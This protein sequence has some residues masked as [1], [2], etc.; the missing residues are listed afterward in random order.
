[1]TKI[2]SIPTYVLLNFGIILLC[3]FFSQLII[4]ESC[5]VFNNE[6][7]L[8]YLSLGL[9]WIFLILIIP[10]LI[11]KKLG[12][13][14]SNI[15]TK[16]FI[17]VMLGV[18]INFSAIIMQLLPQINKIVIVNTDYIGVSGVD[19]VEYSTITEEGTR[20]EYTN[21]YLFYKDDKRKNFELGKLRNEQEC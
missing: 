8:F 10:V 17:M 11:L 13:D 21:S 16:L 7:N 15:L 4:H 20:S 5:S 14:Q 1:M 3:S 2:K 19:D 12:L 18:F 9:I 6:F